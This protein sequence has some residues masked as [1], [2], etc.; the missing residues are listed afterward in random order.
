VKREKRF[1][2]AEKIRSF[3]LKDATPVTNVAEG[4]TSYEVA[5]C[6]TAFIRGKQK[7]YLLQ[8]LATLKEQKWHFTPVG[9]KYSI[10]GPPEPCPYD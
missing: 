10:D 2:R 6:G 3:E 1:A 5:G 9:V 7:G 4:Q 8:T